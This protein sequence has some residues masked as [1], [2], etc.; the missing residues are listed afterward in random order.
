MAKRARRSSRQSSGEGNENTPGAWHVPF[1]EFVNFYRGYIDQ[2]PMEVV[3]RDGDLMRLF[4][5]PGCERYLR[6]LFASDAVEEFDPT[7][8]EEKLALQAALP[9]LERIYDTPS[10]NPS[11]DPSQK[12]LTPDQRQRR[13][14]LRRRAIRAARERLN[15]LDGNKLAADGP[16]VPPEWEGD[17]WEELDRL[18]RRLLCFMHGRGEADLQEVCLAVW[19]DDCADVSESARSTAISKANNFLRKRQ[20]SRQLRQVRRENLLRWADNL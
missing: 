11:S 8:Q 20:S 18:V 1:A 10:H 2:R 12:P 4:Q 14:E 7:P 17:D 13:E 3:R 6:W 5:V 16:S 19:G 15:I 9:A